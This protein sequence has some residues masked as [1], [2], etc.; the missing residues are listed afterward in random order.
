MGRDRKT[1]T[2]LHARLATVSLRAFDRD[3]GAFTLAVTPADQPDCADAEPLTVAFLPSEHISA[4]P[5]GLAE[6][7]D[8]LRAARPG[9]LFTFAGRWVTHSWTSRSGELR[10]TREFEATRLME[11]R[12][13]HATLCG[14]WPDGPLSCPALAA[15]Q[16]M[17]A[18][19]PAAARTPAGPPPCTDR[20][21]PPEPETLPDP[22]PRRRMELPSLTNRAPTSS[23]PTGLTP[24]HI[25]LASLGLGPTRLQPHPG[26]VAQRLTRQLA[27][28]TS[29]PPLSQ[30]P[31]SQ[32][33]FPGRLLGIRPTPRILLTEPTPP[34]ATLTPCNSTTGGPEAGPAA[35]PCRNPDCC[36]PANG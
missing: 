6:F 32:P 24:A 17:E 26:H 15:R 19:L 11:G 4:R 25:S 31:L 33:P 29:Q 9:T 36:R 16:L 27:G 13:D 30:P 5:A 22:F 23:G 35:H 7:E 1:T 8:F 21:A 18:H 20:P 14:P 34:P 10:E 12:H 2:I 3:T 28:P